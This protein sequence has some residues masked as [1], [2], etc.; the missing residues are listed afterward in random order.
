MLHV[1]IVSASFSDSIVSCS[2]F[3]KPI[4]PHHRHVIS[5]SSIINI[6]SVACVVMDSFAKSYQQNFQDARFPWLNFNKVRSGWYDS[7]LIY[8]MRFH[9]D[10]SCCHMDIDISM[11]GLDM[12]PTPISRID[13]DYDP[14]I[15]WYDSDNI[16]I[17]PFPRF[18]TGFRHYSTICSL[19]LPGAIQQV[20][21]YVPPGVWDVMWLDVW[22]STWFGRRT[23]QTF[24]WEKYSEPSEHQWETFG[25][26][27]NL[28]VAMCFFS[29][30]MVHKSKFYSQ[31][32]F[33]CGSQQL[34]WKDAGCQFSIYSRVM[35]T[36]DTM[37]YDICDNIMYDLLGFDMINIWFDMDIMIFDSIW[38]IWCIC[39]MYLYKKWYININMYGLIYTVYGIRYTVFI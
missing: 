7:M 36:Y 38:F 8:E 34:V 33:H 12:I 11:F 6:S 16:L 26:T 1:N 23:A 31:V 19:L 28:K 35:T 14:M 15:H 22:Q 30:S 2:W 37:I 39:I 32:S 5:F 25:K 10:F 4:F 29:A 17:L 24:A 3:G 27:K 18:S 21:T 9:Y 20:A 13:Y